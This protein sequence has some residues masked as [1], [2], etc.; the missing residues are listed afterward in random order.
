MP[1]IPDSIARSVFYLYRS[2]EDARAGVNAGATG[3]M[4]SYDFESISGEVERRCFAVSNWHA[5]VK[6]GYSVI[7]LNTLLG[8]VEVFELGPDEWEFKAG[9]ADIAVAPFDISGDKYSVNSIPSYMFVEREKSSAIAVGENAFMLGLFLDFDGR[10]TP[11]P[12]AR[13]GHVSMVADERARIKQPTK[14]EGESFIVDMHSRSGFSG[15]PVFAYRLSFI[16]F[17]RNGLYEQVL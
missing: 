8:G 5:A 13:F 2:E 3:F 1:R 17:G 14:Y 7:R 6:G 16:G 9:G 15:S 12:V 4:V 10:A 11:V